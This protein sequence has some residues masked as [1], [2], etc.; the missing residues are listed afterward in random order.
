MR[1]EYEYEALPPSPHEDDV[2]TRQEFDAA[3][4]KMKKQ[5][6]TDKDNIPVEVWQ[7]SNVANNLLFEFLPDTNLGQRE[8]ASGAGGRYICD[9]LQKSLPR[10][11]CQL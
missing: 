1:A 8:S 9:D 7:N 6:T 3:V 11:L 10:G 2:L 5:K 4:A